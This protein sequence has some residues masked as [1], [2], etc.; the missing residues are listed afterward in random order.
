MASSEQ[1]KLSLSQNNTSNLSAADTNELAINE[2]VI[3]IN[4]I[5][6]TSKKLTMTYLVMEQKVISNLRVSLQ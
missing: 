5:L 4:M 3:M 1:K 6:K 2:V